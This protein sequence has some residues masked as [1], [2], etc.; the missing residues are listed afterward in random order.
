[1]KKVSV[2][3]AIYNA[4]GYLK[5]CLD[6]LHAQTMQD[7]EFILVLDCPTDGSDSIAKQY[8]KTDSRFII[9]E[10]DANL[11]IGNSRNKG[12]TVAQGEYIA[13]CDHDDVMVPDMYERLYNHATKYSAD[14]VVS[15]PTIEVNKEKSYWSL[16][17]LKQ[18]EDK[19]QMMLKDLLSFGGAM[20]A[21]S[22]YCYIHNVLYKADVIKK[23]SIRFVDT[24]KITNEDVIFNIAYLLHARNVAVLDESLYTHRLIPSSTGHQQAYLDWQKRFREVEYI[25]QLLINTDVYT[26]YQKD[27]YLMAQKKYIDGIIA[28]MLNKEGL[29]ALR[30]AYRYIRNTPYGKAV[31]RNYKDEL[32]RPLLKKIGRRMIAIQLAL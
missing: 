31:F 2:I 32:P 14:F 22:H 16:N 30:K 21:I 25:Y 4:G 6:A 11:H 12:I 15:I 3:I 13:F 8:A 28:I 26:L 1:M 27:F 10:N 7:I 17:S 18:A 19:R 20:Q 23:Q 29:S 24:N 5:D 9:I